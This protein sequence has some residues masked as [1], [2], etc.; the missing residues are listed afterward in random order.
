[1]LGE[2]KNTG[3]GHNFKGTNAKFES[4]PKPSYLNGILTYEDDPL[5]KRTRYDRVD[6]HPR[7]IEPGSRH[8]NWSGG[9]LS[10]GYRWQQP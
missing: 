5:A 2:H 7:A 10:P 9:T 1:M 3:A 4:I 6:V 8:H